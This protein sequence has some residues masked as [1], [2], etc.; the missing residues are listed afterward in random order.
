VAAA[1]P[2]GQQPLERTV[3]PV[4]LFYDLV[5]VVLVGQA[6]HHLAGQL[7]WWG[8]AQFA[9]VFTLIW[10]GVLNG[11]RY[12]DLHGRDDAWGRTV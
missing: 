3:T 1:G 12:H 6:A 2:H 5:V 8:L 7:T 4:E 10:I 11:S 9:A